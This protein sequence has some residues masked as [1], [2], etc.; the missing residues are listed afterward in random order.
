VA[1]LGVGPP[2]IP[3]AELTI[4]RLAQAVAQACAGE[5][6][7]RGAVELGASIIAEDSAARAV[8]LLEAAIGAQYAI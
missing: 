3:R 2:P 1:E 6:M 7:R 5:T 4:E 8:E